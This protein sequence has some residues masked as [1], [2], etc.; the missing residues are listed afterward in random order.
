MSVLLNIQQPDSQLR[1]KHLA[2][3]YH[4]THESCA[5]NIVQPFYIPSAQ[6]YAD[7][8]TKAQQL[9]APLHQYHFKGILYNFGTDGACTID[10]DI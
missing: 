7:P 8:L 5:A 2:I 9:P 10:P 4:V 6:N 3:S 1:K